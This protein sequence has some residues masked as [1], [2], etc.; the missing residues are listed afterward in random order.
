MVRAGHGHGQS[1]QFNGFRVRQTDIT[2][3][4]RL[5]CLPNCYEFYE[6]A[7]LLPSYLANLPSWNLNLEFLN[8]QIPDCR[9]PDSRLIE[10]KVTRLWIVK[11]GQGEAKQRETYEDSMTLPWEV[12]CMNESCHGPGHVS[13]NEFLNC[14]MQ[15]LQQQL[16]LRYYV[17]MHC[18]VTD[19]L[20]HQSL[21][22]GW[23]SRFEIW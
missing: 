23:G 2:W 7:C 6:P 9:L 1:G 18:A 10:L 13:L 5:D 11:E 14:V 19:C 22:L 3:L 16:Q 12:W 17:I 21:N 20:N 4:D 15:Y 8:F